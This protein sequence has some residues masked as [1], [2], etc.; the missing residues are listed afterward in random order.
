MDVETNGLIKR[1]YIQPNEFNLD[2]YPRIVQFSCGIDNTNGELQDSKDYIIK[3]DGWD[4]NL[5]SLIHGITQKQAIEKGTDINIVLNEYK[6]DIESQC[7]KLICHNVNF[8]LKV[9]ASEF[10][11]ARIEIQKVKT[12]C[13]M[14]ET[15]NFCEITP[16]VRGEY[17]WPKLNELYMILFKT[18]M[19]N[20]HNSYYDVINCAKCYFCLIELGWIVA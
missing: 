6:K 13:T 17:K 2:W 14:K 16:K 15:I 5:S 1:P 19:D 7:S 18:E 11:R 3:P 4:V 12:F 10:I 9:V 8:D 20:G